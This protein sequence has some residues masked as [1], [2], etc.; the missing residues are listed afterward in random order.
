MTMSKQEIKSGRMNEVKKAPVKATKEEMRKQ[1]ENM[2]AR[3][4]ELI[5]GTFRN[6]ENQANAGSK[7]AIAFGVKLYPGDP[8]E[9]YELHDGERYSLPRGVVKHLK[10]GC[11]Y[12]EYQQLT[13]ELGQNTGMTTAMHDGR[14]KTKNMQA[15]R[16]IHRFDFNTLD[17]N[18]EDISDLKR[19]DLV[20]V[21]VSP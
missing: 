1:L 12:K 7:G 14:L 8:F 17:F 19:V 6:L 10:Q 13:D 5:T 15:A 2:R 21:T 4:A 18:D 16:K 3:D 20:E 11:F 9:F